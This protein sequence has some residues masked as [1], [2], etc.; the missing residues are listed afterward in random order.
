[1]TIK[2]LRDFIYESYY[3]GIGFPKGGSYYSMK[4]QKKRVFLLL[5]TKLIK[6]YLILVIPKKI[7]NLI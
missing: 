3:R 2:E 4:H 1:M 5:G 6:K 7:I